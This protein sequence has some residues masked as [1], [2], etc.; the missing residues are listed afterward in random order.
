MPSII[1]GGEWSQRVFKRIVEWGDGWLPVVADMDQI[2][3]GMRQMRDLANES[4]C[5]DKKILVNVL[6]GNGQW[7]TRKDIDSFVDLKVDQVTLWLQSRDVDGM[8]KEMD[9]LA[10]DLLA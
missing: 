6:G 2:A 7:R 3:I 4:G 8:R 9:K 1:V 10:A 5:A